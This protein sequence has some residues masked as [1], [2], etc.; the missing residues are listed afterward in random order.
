[1]Y[2]EVIEKECLIGNSILC[3][4][5]KTHEMGQLHHSAFLPYAKHAKF[6]LNLVTYA[7]SL[8]SPLPVIA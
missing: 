2:G 3:I 8:L 1:M 7:T 4:K 6:E 5:K